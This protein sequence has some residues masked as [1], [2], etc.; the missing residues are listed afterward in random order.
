MIQC[1]G[2]GSRYG[3]TSKGVSVVAFRS[4]ELRRLSYVPS[5]DGCEGLYVTPT[6]QGSRAGGTIAQAWATVRCPMLQRFL[7]LVESR[8]CV[9]DNDNGAFCV[10]SRCFTSV[11][12]G[13]P[14]W[15]KR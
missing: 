10:V 7:P 6:L 11:K 1:L 3:H 12:K 9:A 14:K 5:V 13:I 4:A 15:P 8:V 2:S